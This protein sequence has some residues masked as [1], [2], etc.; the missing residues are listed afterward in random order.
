MKKLAAIF[1]SGIIVSSFMLSGCATDT[2]AASTS[3][4]ATENAEPASTA[5]ETTPDEVVELESVFWGNQ[6]EINIVL[7]NIEKFNAETPGVMI[8]GTGIDPSAYLQKLNSYAA[9]NTM[10]DVVQT[11]VDYGD[12][13]TGKGVFEPLDSYI[14]SSGIEGLVSEAMWE[15]VSYNGSVYGVPFT[16]SAPLLIGNKDLF[17]QAGIDFPTDGWSEEE[18]FDAAVAMTDSSAQQYGLMMA[19]W[20]KSFPRALYGTDEYHLYDWSAGTMNAT[21]NPGLENALQLLIVDLM[22]TEN[23][24]PA[25][26]NSTDIGGGFETGKYGMSMIGYWDIRE[27]D[28]VVQD[29]FDWDLLPLP[30]SDEFGQWRTPVYA[31][32]LSVSSVSENKEAA[33]SYLSWTLTNEEVQLNS[34]MMPVNTEITQGDAFLT[35]FADGEKAYTKSLAVDAFNNG[36]AWQ[37]TGVISEINNTVYGTTIEELILKPDSMDLATALQKIQDDGQKL[38][39]TTQE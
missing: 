8:K 33:F 24:A 16:A 27:I 2:P 34:A 7:G 15:N 25:V 19:G 35:T 36:V 31:N 14:E 9:S 10:P 3:T 22:Q 32:V 6:A 21:D 37:N 5:E 20:V 39:D 4:P 17:E 23:A 18:F 12:V 38:F 30:T 28:K 29:T 26:L 1:L 13:Y 11:A